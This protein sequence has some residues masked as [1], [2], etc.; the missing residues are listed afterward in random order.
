MYKGKSI[1]SD[2]IQCIINFILK[3]NHIVGYTEGYCLW[4]AIRNYKITTESISFYHL[5]TNSVFRIINIIIIIIILISLH[6]YNFQHFTIGTRTVVSTYIICALSI[7]SYMY[8]CT[9]FVNC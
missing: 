8:I 6:K 9:V 5:Q 1:I 3:I 4:G 7:I 2:V